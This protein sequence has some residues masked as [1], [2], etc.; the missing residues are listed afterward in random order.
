[1][2]HTIRTFHPLAEVTY[3]F[4]IGFPELLLILALA[5]IVVGPDKLPELAR[6][7]AKT[8]VDLKKT[9]EGLKDSMN[10][11]DNPLNDIKPTLEDAA[12]NF[13][14][15]I[16]DSETAS[17]KVPDDLK[18]LSRANKVTEDYSITTRGESSPPENVPENSND[19]ETHEPR[20]SSEAREPE[21]GDSGTASGESSDGD[22]KK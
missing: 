15:S 16:I 13:K 21:L 4:G 10:V 8:L 17:W 19:T 1:M 5:L 14:E 11:D 22:K 2:C 9:A 12:K 7:I 20:N 18:E 3:M 6:S